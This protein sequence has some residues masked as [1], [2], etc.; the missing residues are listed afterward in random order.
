MDGVLDTAIVVDIYRGYA[1]AAAW[2]AANPHSQFSITPI[3]W[4]E[5]VNGSRDKITQNKILKLL[6]DFSLIYLTSDDFDWAMNQLLLRKLSHNV[7]VNDCLIAAPCQRLSL[8]LYTR[9]LKHFAPLLGTLAQQP[10]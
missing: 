6:Q 9:N 7:G 4:M 3:A 8:P 5:A 10:Y 1:P 2:L